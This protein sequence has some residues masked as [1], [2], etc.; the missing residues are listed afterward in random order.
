M[1]LYFTHSPL[2][3]QLAVHQLTTR[4]TIFAVPYSPPEEYVIHPIT[5]RA[6]FCNSQIY[7]Q[8]NILQF[9]YLPPEEAVIWGALVC[10]CRMYR[11]VHLE[12]PSVFVCIGMGARACN[13]HI[14]NVPTQTYRRLRDKMAVVTVSLAT[15]PDSLT[16]FFVVNAWIWVW[17]YQ[18]FAQSK[19]ASCDQQNIITVRAWVHFSLMILTYT[20]VNFIRKGVPGTTD[21]CWKWHRVGENALQTNRNPAQHTTSGIFWHHHDIPAYPAGTCKQMLPVTMETFFIY[22]LTT[23]F[24]FLQFTYCSPDETLL[25]LLSTRETSC[26]SPQ[27]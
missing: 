4:G 11:S 3:K 5:T 17:R 12:V 27:G 23:R 19:I 22:K 9:T 1:K 14:P 2:E 8:V 10:V 6:T 15:I 21:E 7:H 25:H 16:T 20:C 13:R 18:L 26:S 24:F